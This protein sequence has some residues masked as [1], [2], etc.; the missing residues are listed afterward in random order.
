MIRHAIPLLFAPLRAA[1]VPALLGLLLLASAP[2]AAQR[3][4]LGTEDV[5]LMPG[6][7]LRADTL[8]SF[9]S[10]RG[11]VVSIY[12]GGQLQRAQVLEFYRRSLPPLGWDVV[13]TRL[14]RREGEHL[15][16][17]VEDRGGGVAVHF[18]LVPAN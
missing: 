2:A 1:L 17:D 8:T 5:P 12:G 13:T 16:I 14:F 18:L 6:L 10:A 4:V 15:S 7:S 11:R 3:Y 9:D